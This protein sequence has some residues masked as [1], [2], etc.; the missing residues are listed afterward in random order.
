MTE[1]ITQSTTSPTPNSHD[2]PPVFPLAIPR[3]GE[4]IHTIPVENI[5]R[6]RLEKFAAAN[7]QNC[8]VTAVL[9]P[10]D[11][12][13]SFKVYV[14]GE[15]IGTLRNPELIQDSQ[16]SRVFASGCLVSCALRITLGESYLAHIEI[17]DPER[18]FV[19][20][21]VPLKDWTLLP[22]GRT[23]S[24]EPTKLSPFKKYSA[25]AT[26]LCELR[27]VEGLVYVF[28]DREECGILDVDSAIALLDT[29]SFSRDH[30]VLPMV[31]AFIDR[32]AESDAITFA[33]DALPIQE[34]DS[35]QLQVKPIPALVP[36][37][38]NPR[39]Y[40]IGLS[41]LSNTV[42][43]HPPVPS[44]SSL[45][46]P[47]VCRVTP[48]L[49][50]FLGLLSIILGIHLSSFSPR[51]A[52][53]FLGIGLVG[54]V[55]SA[56]VLYRRSADSE[57]KLAPR[58]WDFIAPLA[59]GITIPSVVFAN[60]GLF[61]DS[62]ESV[63]SFK[64]AD[65]TTLSSIPFEILIASPPIT[66]EPSQSGG[67]F[68]GSD[69]R[70][71]DE[72][73]TLIIAGSELAGSE[74]QANSTRQDATENAR[75]EISIIDSPLMALGTEPHSIALDQAGEADQRAAE[76]TAVTNAPN[77]EDILPGA[78]ITLDLPDATRIRTESDPPVVDEPDD[79]SEP[80]TDLP[81]VPTTSEPS[82]PVATTEPSEP[83]ATTE[84]KPSELAAE[85]TS[86]ADT[87][88]VATAEATEPTP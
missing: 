46:F 58:Y 81:E 47:R 72:H 50:L 22:S 28:L 79:D 37:A 17:G 12:G 1:T 83:V 86:T 33:I 74:S 15:E 27:T 45:K 53:G 69:N 9:V 26:V 30:K 57:F 8:S 59:L 21:S 18:S 68:G 84:V 77:P 70:P 67:L 25:Q 39:E 31:R 73:G 23:W 41:A 34:W 44:Y 13:S 36:Y 14:C 40:R 54:V 38:Q 75:S 76:S 16:I 19:A 51:G 6:E 71:L 78:P 60:I 7:K 65:L 3:S 61:V 24:V 63:S 4:I 48:F 2:H 20:N 82:E 42:E 29:L 49:A 35:C 85:D 55:I 43:D 5:Q 52:V 62:S 10:A 88:E 56:W 11:G 64:N 32:E 66:T 87:S 80:T